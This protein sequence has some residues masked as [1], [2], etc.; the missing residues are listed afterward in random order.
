MGSHETVDW[1]AARTPP[2]S[3]GAEGLRER[4]KAL[5][6]RRLTDAATRMFVARGFDAVRVTEIAAACEVS[7]K[8]VYNYRAGQAGA[9][10]RTG[11]PSLAGEG[12]VAG[13]EL[14]L[15]PIWEGL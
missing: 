3:A 8:T 15:T 6:R 12:P 4:K 1:A 9:E 10:K 11:I 5:T 7:E 14:D 13:F 2:G